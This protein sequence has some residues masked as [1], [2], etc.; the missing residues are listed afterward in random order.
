MI[1]WL[2]SFRRSSFDSLD[3][4]ILK[5]DMHSHLIPSIDDGS[6]SI[7]ETIQLISALKNLGFSKIITTPHTMSDYYKNTPEIINKGTDEVC[8]EIKKRDLKIEFNSASEYYVDYDFI[9]KIGKSQFLTFGSKYLLIEF[10]FVDK[11]KDIDE[12]IFQLQLSGYNVVLAHPERY[13]YYTDKE[14]KKFIKKGVLLQL[15]LLSI[16]GYYSKKVR[17]NAEKLINEDMISFVGT[18]CHNMHHVIKLRECLTN[19]LWHK[20][21]RSE[22]LLNKTL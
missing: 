6:K 14:L 21:S 19:P 1:K 5:T 12:I 13:L 9:Q 11:P 18:D 16:T 7:E 2:S 20:L 15:N 22:N 4:T 8:E 17:K 10:P 3:F